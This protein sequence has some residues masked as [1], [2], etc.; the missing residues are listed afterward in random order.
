M[1]VN[2]Y[3]NE[4]LDLRKYN[5]NGCILSRFEVSLAPRDVNILKLHLRLYPDN[6][7]EVITERGQDWIRKYSSWPLVT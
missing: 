6:P 3:L 2:S 1:W 7:R 4:T 5:Y